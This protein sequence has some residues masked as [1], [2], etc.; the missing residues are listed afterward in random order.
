KNLQARIGDRAR[1]SVGRMAGDRLLP[2]II[3]LGAS[4]AG[5]P[6]ADAEH[7]LHLVLEV[8][9][10]LGEGGAD[11]GIVDLRIISLRDRSAGQH[12]GVGRV[13]AGN[14]GVGSYPPD[15]FM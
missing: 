8:G 15:T 7:A 3:V 13:A 2:L 6:P 10:V 11:R 5:I 12:E 4:Q 1:P 9:A 14:E